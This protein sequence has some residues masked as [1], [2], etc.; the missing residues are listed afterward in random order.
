MNNV[1][2]II[3]SIIIFFIVVRYVMSRSSVARARKSDHFN[4]KKFIN[5]TLE[6]PFS[7]GISDIFKMIREGREAWPQDVKNR[8]TPRLGETREK[9]DVVI[10]FV[11][12][13]TFLIQFSDLNI[14]TDPVWYNRARL[15]G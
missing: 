12:H 6:E 2:L 10:T 1:A 8:A 3:L 9:G 15:V 4:G 14:L 11:N 13:A 7:P 5:P